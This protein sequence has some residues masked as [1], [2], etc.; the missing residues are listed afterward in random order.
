[1]LDH[2]AHRILG[3]EGFEPISDPYHALAELAG[4]VLKVKEVLLQKVEALPSIEDIGA[5]PIATQISVV[6][7]AYERSLDRSASL[8]TNIARLDLDARIAAL[9]SRIDSATAELVSTAMSGALAG[10]SVPA[11][12]QESVMRLFGQL[13]REPPKQ[14]AAIGSGAS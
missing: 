5:G 8:L 14:H 2:E 1:M 7:S 13:L 3:I 9:Q 11:E 12:M 10:A 4:E 6:L